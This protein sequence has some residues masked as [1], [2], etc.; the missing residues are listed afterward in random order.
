MLHVGPDR[1]SGLRFILIEGELHGNKNGGEFIIFK[2]TCK[3]LSTAAMQWKNALPLRVTNVVCYS[4]FTNKLLS[5]RGW[6]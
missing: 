5:E 6:H 3:R 4:F 1:A 2:D